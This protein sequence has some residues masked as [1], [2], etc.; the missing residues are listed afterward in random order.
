VQDTSGADPRKRMRRFFESLYACLVRGARAVLQIYPEDATQVPAPCALPC[1][2]PCCPLLPS[3][4][5]FLPF[6]SPTLCD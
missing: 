5:Q 1:F 6:D 3:L 2:L 4:L